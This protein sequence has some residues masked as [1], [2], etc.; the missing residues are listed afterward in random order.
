MRKG[1]RADGSAGIERYELLKAESVLLDILRGFGTDIA[2]MERLIH[3]AGHILLAGG[4]AVDEAVLRA[5][6]KQPFIG[7]GIFDLGVLISR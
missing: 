1:R 4:E 7:V 5:V 3:D 2:E 6:L